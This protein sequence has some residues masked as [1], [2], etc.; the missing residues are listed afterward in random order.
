MSEVIK[1]HLVCNLSCRFN[2]D[3]AKAHSTLTAGAVPALLVTVL[4]ACDDNIDD[5]KSI[6]TCND[7]IP[8]HI[9]SVMT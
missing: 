4:L 8:W 9:Y 5:N 3:S 2:I 1:P 6:I 7:K